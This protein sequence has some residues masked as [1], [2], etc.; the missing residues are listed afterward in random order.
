[1]AALPCLNRACVVQ[2]KDSR[3]HCRR[4]YGEAVGS[5]FSVLELCT[6]SRS[7]SRAWQF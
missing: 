6:V 3:V 2:Q 1:M 5:V 7:R 4:S